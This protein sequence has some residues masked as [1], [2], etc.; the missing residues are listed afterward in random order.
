M[1]NPRSL[2]HSRHC[3]LP[4]LLA[5][6]AGTWLSTSCRQAPATTPAVQV[7]ADTWAVVD[8]RQI[9]RQDVDKAYLRQGGAEGLSQEEVLA[10]KLTLLN[11]LIV[12]EILLA[13]AGALKLEITQGE[14]DTAYANA[15]RNLPDEAFQEELKRRNLSVDDMREGLRRELLTQKVIEQEV[16]SKISV[17][18]QEVADFFNA[19]RGQFNVAEEAYHI[20]QIVVTPV[21]EAQLS[22]GTGDDATTP[23]AAAAKLKMLLERLK[24]GAS[25]RDLAAGYSEDPDSAPRGGDMGLVPVSRLKQA[26]PALRNAVLNKEPGTVNVLSAGGAHTLVLVVAHE[27]AGQRDL[28]MPEVRE[29]ITQTLRGRREQLLRMAYL[30]NV[31]GEADIVNYLAQRL[32]ESPAAAPGLLQSGPPSR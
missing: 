8:G 15:K 22:N 11:D 27:K 4:A 2:V 6:V 13:K 25:F 10:A 7:S 21:R 24:S 23:E 20:A 1:F 32:V 30:T 18:D 9:T 12:Q 17:T 3:R 26:P 31:R 29:R 19:N 28:S 5:A 16:G 14:L